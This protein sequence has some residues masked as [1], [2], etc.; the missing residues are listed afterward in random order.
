ME[1]LAHSDAERANAPAGSE[2]PGTPQTRPV[3]Q[4]CPAS[5]QPHCPASGPAMKQ[6]ERVWP[7]VVELVQPQVPS[8]LHTEP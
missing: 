4:V 8:L 6:V 7:H 1:L 3:A 2:Q 5:S